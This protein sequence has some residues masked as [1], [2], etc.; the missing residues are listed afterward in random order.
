MDKINGLGTRPERNV[1]FT[2][3]LLSETDD[4]DLQEFVE[5]AARELGAPIALVS[6]GSPRLQTP[7]E[8]DTF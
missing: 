2:G 8:T 6:L 5:E 4:A 3:D 1:A 7:T